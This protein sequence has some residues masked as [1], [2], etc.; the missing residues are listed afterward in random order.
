MVDVNEF[1]GDLSR[2]EVELDLD[3][4]MMLLQENSTLK[5]EIRE[6]KLQHENPW[7]KSID[8]AEIMDAWRVFP[9]MFL[10]AYMYL[11]VRSAEWFMALPDPNTQQAGL[12]SVLLTAG[13]AFFGFYVNTGKK[14]FDISK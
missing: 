13:S 2:N 4:F 7:Q 9:R 5:D 14:R 12:V 11:L 10:G 8:F 3:K 1:H 6:L